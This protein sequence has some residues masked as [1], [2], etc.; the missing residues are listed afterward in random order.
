MQQE[1]SKTRY[2][3]PVFA[4]RDSFD[5]IIGRVDERQESFLWTLDSLNYSSLNTFFMLDG[6]QNSGSVLHDSGAAT[7]S[8]NETHTLHVPAVPAKINRHLQE[9]VI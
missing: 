3:M 6:D 5:R 4:C 9:K 8:A 7:Y 1:Q 2:I